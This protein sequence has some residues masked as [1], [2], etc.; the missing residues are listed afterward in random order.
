MGRRTT[1]FGSTTG[2]EA[3]A[4]VCTTQ[5]L[6]RDVMEQPTVKGAAE[7]SLAY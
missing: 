4:I 5:D 6:F 1:E 7:N 2:E 3:V